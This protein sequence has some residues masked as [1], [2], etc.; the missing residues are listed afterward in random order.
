M[1]IFKHIRT[2]MSASAHQRVRPASHHHRII[3][4]SS[5]LHHRFISKSLCHHRIIIASSSHHIR[6]FASSSHHLEAA[7]KFFPLHLPNSFCKLLPAKDLPLEPARLSLH[8]S[9]RLSAVPSASKSN[10]FPSHLH[11]VLYVVLHTFTSYCT[12]QAVSAKFT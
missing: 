10:S 4:A 5:S 8:N 1:V 3:I 9:G 11:L 7:N 12:Q 2:R 6:I